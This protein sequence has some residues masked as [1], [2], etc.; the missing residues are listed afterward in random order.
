MSWRG[1]A[2]RRRGVRACGD[3]SGGVRIHAFSCSGGLFLLKPSPLHPR[4]YSLPVSQMRS[5][6]APLHAWRGSA[7]DGAAETGDGSGRRRERGSDDFSEER[8]TCR[9][10]L[11]LLNTLFT[12]CSM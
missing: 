5:G 7:K 1:V 10:A 12:A 3:G 2:K 9:G 8:G 4:T 6:F 11:P